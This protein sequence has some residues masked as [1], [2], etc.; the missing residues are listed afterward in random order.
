[1]NKVTKGTNNQEY[2]DEYEIDLREYIKLIWD[3]KFFIISLV[4]VM[5]ILAGIYSFYIV[6]PVYQ[7][8]TTVQLSNTEDFYS[9]PATAM[10]LLKSNAIVMPIMNE[11]G[12]EYSEADL[13]GYLEANMTLGNPN[14]TQIIDISLE[15]TDPIIAKQVLNDAIISYKKK[16]DVQYNKAI[17]N[18][19]KNLSVIESNID[20]LDKQTKSV[21]QNINNISESDLSP[22]EK[23]VLISGLTNKLSAYIEQRNSFVTEKRE[24]EEYLLSYQPFQILNQPYVSEDPVS[25]NKRL[26]LAI[27]AVLGLMTAIFLVFFIEF[28]KEDEE[29]KG[30]IDNE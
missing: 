13:Q 2:Y 9:N 3:N 25:P 4:I 14:G 19:Q 23:S 21:N 7:A 15:N 20:S 18:S 10:R 16:A 12:Q 30:G 26:N 8:H 24:I 17:N 1:M 29:T 27:A 22:T 6:D 11:L 28:L 5:T